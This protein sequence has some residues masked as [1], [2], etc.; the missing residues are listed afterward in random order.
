LGI[1]RS[2]IGGE[3]TDVERMAVRIGYILPVGVLR[4]ECYLA[5]NAARFDP[6]IRVKD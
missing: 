6:G 2:E 4:L 3:D 5:D 1:A